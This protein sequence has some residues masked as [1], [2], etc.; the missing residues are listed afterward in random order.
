MAALARVVQ[1]EIARGRTRPVGSCATDAGPTARV[2][3]DPSSISHVAIQN[4]GGGGWKWLELAAGKRFERAVPRPISAAGAAAGGATTLAGDGGGDLMDRVC[5]A[6]QPYYC[7]V[8]S[9][10]MVLQGGEEGF[11]PP[12]DASPYY[13]SSDPS[14]P[15]AEREISYE[16]CE[17]IV[18]LFQTSSDVAELLPEGI[19]PLSDPPM[20]AVMLTHYPFSTVGEYNEY[21]ALIQVEDLDGEPAFYIPYIYVTNDRALIAGREM[22][23]APKKLARME[24]DTEGSIVSGSLERPAGTPL[25]ELTVAPDQ[26]AVGGMLDT[27]MGE[28]MPLLSIRHLPPIEG[29]DGCTQLVKWYADVDFHED[30][31][32][33]PKRWMGSGTLEYP[34]ESPHDPV[35]R[36]PVDHELAT[37][38]G[39]FDM[40]L[41]ATEVHETWEL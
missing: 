19:V 16:D 39:Q 6:T 37:V 32:G 21:L 23:G 22:A 10:T 35:H 28:R 29:G 38:Y 26:R 20:A 31:Q 24:L 30:A 4:V 13:R 25:A 5:A 3:A 7:L 36:V 11:A 18:S 9:L 15:A 12:F 27:L 8:L 34:A 33:R 40:A 1:S 14:T 2:A 17:A 41:G